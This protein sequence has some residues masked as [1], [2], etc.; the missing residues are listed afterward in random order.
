LATS[1][2]ACEGLGKRFG[3]T[4]ALGGLDLAVPEGAVY[5]LLGPNGAGKTTA[6]RVLT[7]LL[8]PDSGHA[9][10]A[11]FDVARQAA[12]VRACIGL[13]GQNAAVDEILS[14]RQNLVMFGRLC[15]LPVSATR[16]R[17]HDLLGQ[18]ALADVA[19][20]PVRQYSGGMRRRLD[21]AVSFIVAPRVLFLDEPTTGLDPH[22]RNE[23]WQTIRTLAGGGTTVLLTTQY[24]EEADQLADAI[25]IMAAGRVVA[26]GTPD[27]LKSLAG[28]DRIKVVLRAA[29]DLVPAARLLQ[30]RLRT[31][32]RL[33]HDR[34]ELSLPVTDRLAALTEIIRSLQ[35]EAITAED[36]AVRRPTLDEAFLHL[37]GRQPP[38]RD[39]AAPSAQPAEVNT[40]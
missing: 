7:T 31:D 35:Q 26:E 36:I 12:Q 34:R 33:D 29:G 28:G 19:G 10:V 8:R 6:V 27:E 5:G 18:F 4:T 30:A 3:E 20:Q 40:L 2:I 9:R 39:I 14:G 16:R 23:V 38:A 1:A 13:A 32:V 24:L 15:H 37:T 11:G 17:A 21:L 22:G 25:A